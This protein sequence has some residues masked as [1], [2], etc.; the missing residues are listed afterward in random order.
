MVF[1]TDKANT[2]YNIASPEEYL[3]T[4]AID[5]RNNQNIDVSIEDLPVDPAYV[6]SLESLD[7]P[8]FFTSKWLNGVLVQTEPNKVSLIES[9]DFVREVEF[10]A[11]G[12]RLLSNS[13]Q[14]KQNK[15]EG[16]EF[17]G[18]LSSSFQLNIL[19][20]DH[21]HSQGQI[22]QGRLIAFLDGGF[23][24]V[25][26]SE[27]FSH[28][29]DSGRMKGVYNFVLNNEEPYQLSTHGTRVFSAV[30][31]FEE[32]TYTGAAY[33]A[34][35][36]LLVTEDNS[37]EYRVE[38]YNWLFGAEFA[39]S[40]GVDII[41]ASVGYFDFDDS[42]MNYDYD[43]L[44]GA[45]TVVTRAADKASSKGILV[46]VSAGN[47]GNSPWMF[48]TAPAD[49]DSVLAV[50]SIDRLEEKSSFSSFGPSADGRIKPDVMAIGS[51]TSVITSDGSV[52]TSSGTSFSSP[53]I[54]GMAAL[55][56]NESPELSNMELLD[57]IRNMGNRASNPDNLNGYG[58][59]RIVVDPTNNDPFDIIA[60]PNPIFSDNLNINFGVLESTLE[61][62]LTLYD[63]LGNELSENI[64]DVD[65][66]LCEA[67][68][69]VAS[70]PQGPYILQISS[71][72]VS[73]RLRI[74]RN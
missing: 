35:F 2:P 74:I 73:K 4:R 26:D 72:L 71:A 17:E 39:D 32:D 49:G 47:E 63:L 43:D 6:D 21:L 5:R 14:K 20:I 60:F 53:L 12:E 33:G 68:L 57:K 28:I 45:T 22:G 42:T 1:F 55:L 70:L 66:G 52:I 8:T 44:D 27:A 24:G 36:M 50:G 64:L 58:V 13:R 18:P 25:D 34:E 29:F 41:N 59:P 69:D 16:S 3:S 15:E 56:W 9:L 61:V 38:E 10:V 62:T 65:P 51:G 37:S 54:A 30:A 19:G 48:I 7:I 11:P 46:V 31:A 40:A 23:L 67:R